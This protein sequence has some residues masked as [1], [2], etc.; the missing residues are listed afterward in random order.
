MAII[1]EHIQLA[2]QRKHRSRYGINMV[3]IR[4]KKDKGHQIHERKLEGKI[5]KEE[6]EE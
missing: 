4:G 2:Y 6:S 1:I 5:I 3:K